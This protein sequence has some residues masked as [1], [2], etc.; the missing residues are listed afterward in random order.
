MPTMAEFIA[1]AFNPKGLSNMVDKYAPSKIQPTIQPPTKLTF[2]HTHYNTHN[3]S[4]S[5][6]NFFAGK[7]FRQ[8]TP[9]S[10]ER[11]KLFTR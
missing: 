1:A 2:A 11:N 7:G 9:I 6:F 3:I 5:T 8:V 10:Y 4:N